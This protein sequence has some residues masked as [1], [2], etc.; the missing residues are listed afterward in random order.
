MEAPKVEGI[1]IKAFSEYKKLQT[2]DFPN[3]K[4]IDI[5]AFYKNY[6]KTLVLPSSLKLIWPKA[7]AECKIGKIFYKGTSEEFTFSASFEPGTHIIG[8]DKVI[9]V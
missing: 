5:Y 2:I 3:L 9:K 6:I 7:F 4:Q 1:G 8:S